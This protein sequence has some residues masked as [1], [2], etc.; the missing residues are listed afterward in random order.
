[1]DFQKN[2]NKI[3]AEQDNQG[4]VFN[5]YKYI[6]LILPIQSFCKVFD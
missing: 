6:V 4:K 3:N 5:L 2:E 1:M